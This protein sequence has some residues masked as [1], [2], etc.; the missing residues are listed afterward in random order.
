MDFTQIP[1]SLNYQKK[2]KAELSKLHSDIIVNFSKNCELNYTNK[3]K[4]I[5]VLNIVSYL[6]ISGDAFPTDW[7]SSHPLDMSV[8]SYLDTI[9]LVDYL[10]DLYISYKEISWDI[11]KNDFALE[12][13]NE[14]KRLEKP[15]I[16][17]TVSHGSGVTIIDK[18]DIK[19]PI[20][21]VLLEPRKIPLFDFSKPW[22]RQSIHGVTYTIPTSLPL[23][24]ERS[25]DITVS[26]DVNMMSDFDIDKLFPNWFMHTRGV[27][28]YKP[29]DGVEL[30]PDFGLIFQFDGF[31]REQVIDNII[32]YPYLYNVTR[33]VD[34]SVQDFYLNIEIS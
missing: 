7:K 25:Q 29:L 33:F 22:L 3:R 2:Y 32:K 27:S 30:D 24:P 20:E 1:D 15:D 9:D 19:T 16:H 18:V 34:G 23:K 28:L 4:I 12:T 5:D 11:T 13:F 14:Q 6:V 17:I 10:N 21:D 31:T 8:E 26:T